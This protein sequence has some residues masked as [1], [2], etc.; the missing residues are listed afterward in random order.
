MVSIQNL[1]PVKDSTLQELGLSWVKESNNSALNQLIEVTQS[2]AEAYYEAANELY[3]MYIEAAEYVIN[4]NL[5]FE[6]GIPFNIVDAIKK[7]WENDV[8]WHIYGAFKFAGGVA[9]K[10]IKLLGFEADCTNHL[11]E[12]AQLQ[13]AILQENNID[14]N[15]QFNE[16]YEKITENFQR[17]ITLDDGLEHFDERYDGWKILFSSLKNT[18]D[19]ATTRLLQQMADEAGYVNEFSYI[20]EVLFDEESISDKHS[21]KFEY[22]YKHIKWLDIATDESELAT[23][24]TSIMKNQE[25]IVIN[26][27]YTLLFES[28]GML[29]ILKELYPDS[30]YLLDSSFDKNDDY[31]EKTVFGDGDEYS[32]FKKV[33]HEQPPTL[34]DVHNSSYEAKVFFAYEA[35]GLCF[36]K[37]DDKFVGHI[38]L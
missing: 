20:D 21:N 34:H 31:I 27:A 17:L 19:E 22:W 6:L 18:K 24:L 25:A 2:E 3:D 32:N 13:W 11:F 5:F 9:N 38:M 33:Y 8:H 29:T 1:E 26:P 14:E 16:I 12:A 30:P 4:N 23:T 15:N 36:T 37:D 10:N 7:S 35:C 28:K